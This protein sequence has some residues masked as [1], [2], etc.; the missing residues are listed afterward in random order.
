MKHRV[1]SYLTVVAAILLMASCVS[2]R[3]LERSPMVGGL[4]GEAYV[5]KVIA[6]APEW[7]SVTGKVA[8]NLDMGDKGKA[9]VNATVR[10]RKGEVIQFSVAP[11]LGIEVARMEI[12]PEGLL[13]IDRMNKRYVEVS[14][15]M[16]SGLANMELSFG[17]LQSL[18]LNE[19]F[20]PG[21]NVLD[22]DDVK[23]FR[24]VQD[25]A[26]VRLQVRSGKEFDYTF[27]TSADQ[28]LLEKTEIGL[29]GTDYVLDWNY[30]DFGVLD[31]KPFPQ[32][33]LLTVGGVRSD[34]SLEMKFSRLSVDDHWEGRTKVSSRYRK[35]ELVELLKMLK[36]V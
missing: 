24:I 6:A 7:K 9:K 19:L 33:M 8:L 14:Y 28:G 17:V 25:E 2:R 11:L 10:I 20:L 31:R 1:L 34:L 36:G 22:A 21:K 13:L 29:R 30:D 35:V 5:E 16:L 12:T 23:R 4:T 18:F 32:H 15:A 3:S 27:H 26:G